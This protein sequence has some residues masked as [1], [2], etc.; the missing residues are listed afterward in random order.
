M[1]LTLIEFEIAVA[2]GIILFLLQ[3]AITFLGAKLRP[4]D[5]PPEIIQQTEKNTK[6]MR[7]IMY[8]SAILLPLILLI[9]FYFT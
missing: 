7:V 9:Y 3:L 1:V 4:N 5:L 6:L 2:G 8:T